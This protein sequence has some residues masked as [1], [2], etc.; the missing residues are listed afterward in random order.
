MLQQN[1]HLQDSP[2]LLEYKQRQFLVPLVNLQELP[3][4]SI[5]VE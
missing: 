5:Q 4:N 3:Y 1:K 2:L